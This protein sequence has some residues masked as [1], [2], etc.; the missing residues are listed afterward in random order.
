MDHISS[1][2]IGDDFRPMYHQ[3][4]LFDSS[5]HNFHTFP[6]EVGWEF[7]DDRE[8][9]PIVKGTATD[10]N[11]FL[12]SWLFFGLL[13]TVIQ[14]PQNRNLILGDFLSEDR[15]S[16]DTKRLSGYLEEWRNHEVDMKDDHT[17][18]MIRTQ[19]ALDRAREVVRD[20]CS[21]D[22][23]HY[24]KQQIHP[25]LCL[26]LMVLGETLSNAKSKIV[27]KLGCNIRGWYGDATE[28]WGSPECLLEKMKNTGGWCPGT[29][30]VLRGQLKSMATS[31]LAAS[32][33]H[34]AEI[35]KQRSHINCNDAHPCQHT[36]VDGHGKYQRRHTP[37]CPNAKECRSIGPLIEDILTTI[38]GD[39]YPLLSYDGELGTVT[40]HSCEPHQHYAT[41]SHVWADGYGNPDKNELWQCQLNF[42]QNLFRELPGGK[43]R[44]KLYFWIDTLAVPV[45]RSKRERELRDRAIKKIHD[46]YNKARYTIVVDDALTQMGQGTTYEGAAMRILASGWMRRLWT[47][48]EAY[49]SRRLMFAFKYNQLKNLDDLE[50]TYNKA[51]DVLTSSIATAA[52]DY[53]HNMLGQHRNARMSELSSSSGSGLLASVWRASQWRVSLS[54][55]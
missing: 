30:R 44:G 55:S 10:I 12:Q 50:D 19:V 4:N 46:I 22:G 36:P 35:L 51:S 15:G 7:K 43:H 17:I 32:Y 47:L 54:H 23:Q 1:L 34:D 3:E 24:R 5:Q 45:G 28:G 40:V 13:E 29:L 21:M 39:N 20:H 8:L 18:R 6:E 38:E 27:E 42:F 11:H 48:Q 26:S 53:F 52:R 16:I 25:E 14:L 49:V 37:Q 33:S 31:L 41:I 2:A 9:S